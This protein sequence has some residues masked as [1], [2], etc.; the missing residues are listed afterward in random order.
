VEKDTEDW[1]FKLVVL[2][3]ADLDQN[4]EPD[5]IMF[6][7]DEA[8]KGSYRGYSTIIIYNAKPDGLLTAMTMR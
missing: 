3:D 2:A 4:G 8:K 1:H 5:W 7:S 6:L